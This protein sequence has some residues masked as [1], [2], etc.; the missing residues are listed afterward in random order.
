M[1]H[2]VG[3]F[4]ERAGLVNCLDRTMLTGDRLICNLHLD[5]V[6]TCRTAYG[7]EASYKWLLRDVDHIE[8]RV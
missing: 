4:K 2:L 8:A 3:E 5:H 6:A 1:Q 7:E